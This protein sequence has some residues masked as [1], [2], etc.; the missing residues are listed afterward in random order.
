MTVSKD[1]KRA[2]E[3]L[4]SDRFVTEAQQMKRASAA[5]TVINI[6]RATSKTCEQNKHFNAQQRRMK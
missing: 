4:Q 3:P 5:L 2:C 6:A 1:A